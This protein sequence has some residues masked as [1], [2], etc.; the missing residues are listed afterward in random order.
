VARLRLV[1]I[2][3]AAAGLSACGGGSSP[4]EP[5]LPPATYSLSV[6]VFYDENANGVLDPQEGVRLPSV[7]VTA[8]GRSAQTGE[9][10]V[11]T[12]D[13]LPAGTLTV[14]VQASSLPAFWREGQSAP[15][16]VPQ[17]SQALV[18]VTLPIGANR[19]NVYMAFGDSIT[20]GEGSS[21]G[22]G[23]LGILERRLAAHFGRATVENEGIS[24]TRSN[25]GAARVVD[26]LTGRTPAYILIQYGTNDWNDTACRNVVP[27]FTIDSLGTM[28]REAKAAGT[29][30]VLAT[31][32][33]VNVGY[34]AR[35]PE[36][37][38]NWVSQQDE[39]IRSLAVQEG[40]LLV[41]LEKAFLRAP[42]LG[43]LFFDHIHPNDAGYEIIAE[44]FFEALT[45]PRGTTAGA[46][47]V[48]ASPA[49]VVPAEAPIPFASRGRG[50]PEVPWSRP[51]RP[52]R[53]G[54]AR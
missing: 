28:V 15:L 52:G 53:S 41:D 25:R 33:P 11:A 4:S 10:G 50:G 40:A 14:A 2:C 17:T 3:G 54:P 42:E 23:Y 1:L 20:V 49:R 39:L 29:M 36:S 9:A 8:A 12:L 35:V 26:S 37:R 21:D 38:Q 16:S 7:T 34:D 6:L 13:G 24:A 47:W 48:E 45:R 22:T 44:A 30:P 19:P 43:D 51:E 27:C 5:S 18:P 31:I 46:A 32:I